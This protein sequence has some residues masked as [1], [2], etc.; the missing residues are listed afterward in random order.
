MEVLQK[1]WF[2]STCTGESLQDNLIS[3]MSWSFDK[4]PALLKCPR[5]TPNLNQHDSN[6]PPSVPAQFNLLI[7]HK[8]LCNISHNGDSSL[9]LTKE[10]R[11]RE[12]ERE[13]EISDLNIILSLN[14][15]KW[16]Q[17]THQ[18]HLL[19]MLHEKNKWFVRLWGEKSI[20]H[21]N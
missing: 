7:M 14:S 10:K 12:R 5:L 11:E 2:R 9:S 4:I 13:I 16:K 15:N 3:S 17:L 8:E 6:V 21:V 18:F 20:Y 1:S 19:I